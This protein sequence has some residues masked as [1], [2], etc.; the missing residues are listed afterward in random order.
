MSGLL[1]VAISGIRAQQLRLDSVGYNLANLSTSGFKAERIDLQDSPYP[2][3]II[4]VT[5]RA[6]G[7]SISLEIPLGTGVAGNASRIVRQGALQPSGI[8]TDFAIAGPGLFQVRLPD[9]TLA[10][11]RN[12]AFTLDGEGRLVTQDGYALEPPVRLPYGWRTVTIGEDGTVTAADAS[13]N[14]LGV[15]GTIQI[16]GFRNPEGLI[17]AGHGLFVPGES[18]GAAALGA[19]GA[20]GRGQV[21]AGSLEASNVDISEEMVTLI[22]AQRAYQMTAR[23]LQSLLQMLEQASALEQ[24]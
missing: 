19:P 9:G 17:P 20:A 16:A 18:S 3:H 22:E 24:R 13:G 2:V 10:Y 11:T 1:N 4:T 5:P 14:S 7:P 21:V 8:A 12:G 23:T 15:A 6:D